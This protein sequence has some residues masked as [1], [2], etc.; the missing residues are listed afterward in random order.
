MMDGSMSTNPYESPRSDTTRRS[1]PN[2]E[3]VAAMRRLRFALLILLV[4]AIYNFFCSHYPTAAGREVPMHVMYRAINGAGCAAMV[5]AIWFFGLAALEF[6]TGGIHTVLAR[7]SKLD[8]WKA[9]LYET[10]RRAPG[11]AVGGA[12]LWSVWCFA[13]YQLGIEFYTVSLPIG[14]AAHVLAAALYVPLF[15]RWYQA[16]RFA[17]AEMTA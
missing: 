5:L 16:E 10:L 7:N 17:E 15:Y 8:A 1:L 9:T 14:F 4:P 2:D 3:R 11:F 12:A 13:I 6:V